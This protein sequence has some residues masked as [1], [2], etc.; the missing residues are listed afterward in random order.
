MK[1]TKRVPAS[2]VLFMMTSA[3]M[4]PVWAQEEDG[5]WRAEIL[6]GAVVGTQRMGGADLGAG[7]GFQANL[8]FRFLPHVS[9]YGGWDWHRFN[10]NVPF[11]GNNTDVEETG[12]AFGLRFEHPI[13]SSSRTLV[14]RGGGTYNHIELENAAGKLV[15]DSGHG[16]GWEAGAGI[17]FRVGDRW[18]ITPGVRFR[19]LFRDLV[20]ANVTN[21]VT[22]RYVAFEIGFARIF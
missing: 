1:T 15:S 3:V 11:A 17:G 10:T 12:Y 6:P 4:M 5:R 16:L 21:P 14:L 9:T 7:G 19:S 2:L 20:V 13:R 22:L 18:R 8:S